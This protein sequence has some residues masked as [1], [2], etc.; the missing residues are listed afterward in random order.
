MSDGISK[1]FWSTIR[2]SL[3]EGKK[4]K[5]SNVSKISSKER[6]DRCQELKLYIEELVLRVF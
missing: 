2:E 1:N 5:V 3:L 4:G 6:V